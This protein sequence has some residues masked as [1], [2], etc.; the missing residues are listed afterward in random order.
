M[1]NKPNMIAIAVMAAGGRQ[2]VAAE[3]GDVTPWAITGWQRTNRMPAHKIRPL[4]ALGGDVVKPDQLLAYIEE[5][6]AAKIVGA[7]A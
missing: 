1:S 5:C 2:A 4:C 3:F 6:E 7:D